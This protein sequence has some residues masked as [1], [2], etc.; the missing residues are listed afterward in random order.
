MLT[1][2]PCYLDHAAHRYIWEPHDL[3]MTTSV[4]G[5]IHHFDPPYSGPEEAGWRGTHTHRAMEALALKQPLPDPISPEGVDCTDWFNQISGM[6]FWNQIEVIACEYSMVSLQKS[7]GGQLDLLCRYKDRV[8]LVD[9]KSKG[10]SWTSASKDDIREYAAQAGGYMHLLTNGD[11]IPSVSELPLIDEC[12]T[13]VITPTRVKWLSAMDPD[14]FCTPAWEECWN[15]YEMA[16][17]FYIANS[18]KQLTTT[19]H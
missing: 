14:G 15:K 18:Q 5:V 13:L 9:L 2:R 7:L 3:E 17:P 6:S 12:R 11:G 16:D 1:K 4:T 19:T 10:P 8:L